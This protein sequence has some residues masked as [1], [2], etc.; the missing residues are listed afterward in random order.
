MFVHLVEAFSAAAPV[1]FEADIDEVCQVLAEL[2]LPDEETH[3]TQ[4]LW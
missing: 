4:V 3:L 2:A 1:A